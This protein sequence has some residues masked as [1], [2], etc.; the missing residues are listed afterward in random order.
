ML[1]F[2]GTRPL[3]EQERKASALDAHKWNWKDVEADN[4][5]VYKIDLNSIMH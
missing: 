2:A 5:A 3:Q 4:G 1:V